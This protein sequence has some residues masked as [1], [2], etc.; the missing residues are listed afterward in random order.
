MIDRDKIIAAFIGVVIIL[1]ALVFCGTAR[2]DHQTPPTS[3]W[4]APPPGPVC[5]A[6]VTAE[7]RVEQHLDW[8]A[9]AEVVEAVTGEGLVQWLTAYN[10]RPPKSVFILDKVTALKS[11]VWGGRY[12]VVFARGG[13]MITEGLMDIKVFEGLKRGLRRDA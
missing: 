13:C 5:V 11:S 10:D 1:A 9:G 6:N 4:I 3:G 2:A 7:E 8:I 12:L